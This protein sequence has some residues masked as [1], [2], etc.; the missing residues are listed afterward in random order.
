M[1][2]ASMTKNEILE[3]VAVY[4][5]GYKATVQAQEEGTRIVIDV[6]SPDFDNPPAYRND[7]THSYSSSY[8]TNIT[9]SDEEITNVNLEPSN[10]GV[11]IT[12]QA[13]IS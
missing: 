12:L 6:I 11:G 10:T 13:P 4:L 5:D 7:D 3:I 8:L 9:S 2:I 1:E